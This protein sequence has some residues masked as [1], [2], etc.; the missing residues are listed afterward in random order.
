MIPKGKD[1]FLCNGK[2]LDE[3]T[4]LYYYG[5]R[6]Y[7]PRES[8]WLSVDP[9]AEKYPNFSPYAYTFQNPIKY[10]DPLGLEGE[11]VNGPGDPPKKELQSVADGYGDLY[12]RTYT[13][14]ITDSKK[15]A[16]EIF[17][18]I[19][20]NFSK[21]TK[22]Q[23]YFYIYSGGEGEFLQEGDQIGIVGGP[24]YMESNRKNYYN[25]AQ[26]EETKKAS[27]AVA[28]NKG[29]IY[30][31][32]THTGVTVMNS[33]MDDDKCIYSMMF[34]TWKGHPE[35]GTITFTAS[36]TGNNVTFKISSNL[37]VGTFSA[38]MGYDSFIS[39]FGY[40]AQT[41][42][43]TTFLNNVSKYSGSTKSNTVNYKNNVVPYKNK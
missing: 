25:D 19:N 4:G 12:Q 3:E 6:Y 5:A 17:K 22:G 18:D 1:L 9:L 37:R 11:E 21:Y 35:A 2:E 27:Y 32:M 26:Y 34:Q 41:A 15:T 40:D 7:N 42:H 38:W 10:V 29:N 28:D 39:S 16:K 36:G 20:Q 31:G 14:S 13:I 23:S 33:Y 30:I 43:W 24:I 8:V